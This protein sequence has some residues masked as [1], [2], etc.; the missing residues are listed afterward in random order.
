MTEKFVHKVLTLSGAAQRLVS[1]FTD[2]T[3]G[4]ADDP[5]C[6][7]ITLQAGSANA[8]VVR[9]GGNS[10]VA[11]GDYG[12]VIPIPTATVP[13]APIVLQGHLR[14]SMVWVIGANTE[15]LHMTLSVI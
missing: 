9:V 1:A 4:G 5:L 12:I 13:A 7:E 2:T 11:A 10:G 14:P 3:P 15:K 6:D 8:A